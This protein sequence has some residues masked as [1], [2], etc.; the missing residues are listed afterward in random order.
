M[1][2]QLQLQ[3]LEYEYN[4]VKEIVELP[5]SR[6]ISFPSLEVD[7]FGTQQVINKVAQS[8]SL[9]SLETT[10]H[11]DTGGVRV[12]IQKMRPSSTDKVGFEWYGE[13]DREEF[14]SGRVI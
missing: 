1:S 10:G 11:L 9:G 5:L 14:I 12:V 4:Y 2:V 6:D 8:R 7:S 13:P 3:A